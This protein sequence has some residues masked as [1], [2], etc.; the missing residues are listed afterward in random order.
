MLR[1]KGDPF[2][3]V[4]DRPNRVIDLVDQGGG[5]GVADL[6]DK[7]G[8]IFEVIILAVISLMEFSRPRACK[9]CD[10]G[11]HEKCARS[12]SFVLI[13]DLSSEPLRSHLIG[14]PM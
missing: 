11:I 5:D 10:G 6:I 3:A 4:N 13:G 12:G 14:L 9:Y 8:F 1:G 2:G 7:F